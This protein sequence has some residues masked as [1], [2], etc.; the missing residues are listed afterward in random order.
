VT[1]AHFRSRVEAGSRLY[2][3]VRDAARWICLGPIVK[4]SPA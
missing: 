4:Q 3:V 1:V 2:R